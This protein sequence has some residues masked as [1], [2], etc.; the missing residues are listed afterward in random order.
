MVT[1]T[2]RL[3]RNAKIADGMWRTISTISL[4]YTELTPIASRIHEGR[5][6]ED[7]WWVETVPF[8]NELFKPSL[9]ALGNVSLVS[10]FMLN[11]LIPKNRNKALQQNPPNES[12]LY[13]CAPHPIIVYLRTVNTLFLPF[14]CASAVNQTR[15]VEPA[16]VCNFTRLRLNHDETKQAS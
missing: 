4:A 11:L 13:F 8:L 10:K 3:E 2:A 15:L 6:S 14:W 5:Q 12:I 9:V 7:C 16:I 1:M